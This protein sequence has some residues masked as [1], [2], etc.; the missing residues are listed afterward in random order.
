MAN[1]AESTEIVGEAADRAPGASGALRIAVLGLNAWAVV[2]FV[3]VLFEPRKTAGVLAIAA[4][5]LLAGGVRAL[6]RW[7]SAASW[8]LLGAFPATLAAGVASLPRDGDQPMQGTVSL[9]LAAV[10]FIAFILVTAR[11]CARPPSIRPEATRP[12]DEANGAPVPASRRAVAR[13]AFLAIAAAGAFTLVTVAPT[14]GTRRRLELA[15]NGA[16][17]EA[18]V[19]TAVFAGVIAISALALIVA[20]AMRRRR[21]RRRPPTRQLQIRVALLV[22]L[23]LLGLYVHYL[24]G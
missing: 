22:A 7:P 1:Y 14:W 23:A 21:P 24:V 12:L 18:A 6:L 16:A 13:G 10:S 9:A 5:A 11:A 19:L 4:L 17:D 8:T 3:P 20:P 2:V 15:W